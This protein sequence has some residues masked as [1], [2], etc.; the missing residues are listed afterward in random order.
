MANTAKALKNSA[1]SVLGQLLNLI[2]RFASRRIFI[3]FLD[4]EYLG[5]HSLFSNVLGLLSLTELG[6]GNVISFHLFKE[7][8]QNKKEE[9]GKL[10]FIY[11]WVYR[12]IALVVAILG[13]VAWFFL[14]KIVKNTTLSIEYVNTIYFLQL[15]SMVL[16]YL[17]AYKRNMFIADQKEYKCIKYDLIISIV[18]QIIA[19]IMLAF[20][21]SY[22]IYLILQ[23]S[24]TL[25]STLLISYETDISYPYLN[26]KYSVTM[27]DINKYNFIPDTKNFILHKVCYTVYS[28]TDNILISMYCGVRNVA[29]YGNYYTIQ[30]GILNILFYRLLNPIQATIGNIIY[31]QRPKE[32]LW[33][34]F[35]I[36]DFA[37]WYLACYTALGF[38]IF[39]QPVIELWMGKEYLLP[40]S[41][42]I[43]YVITIYFIASWEI[44][45]KYRSVFG[46]FQQDRNCMVLSA[47]LNII[48]SVILA[49]HLEI[50]GIQ[51]GTFFA[52]LPIAYGRIRFVVKNYFN[53]SIIK[54]Y[55]KHI[56]LF[57]IFVLDASIAWRITY[58]LPNTF[59]NFTIRVCVWFLI[60][61]TI[62][63]LFF[64]KTEDFKGVKSYANK[65]KEIIISKLKKIC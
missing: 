42:V 12:I 20:T 47:V 8:A 22:I 15:I 9:I 35:K 24:I 57:T 10:M 1:F 65:V 37:C 11:K 46:N 62:N 48:I 14:P 18:M 33:K 17:L 21:K 4:I 40:Y 19:L 64:F 7:I 51:I 34:Q 29:L 52:F 5:Y 45:Y 13:V 49:T 23:L 63:T 3:I 61:L 50:T 26:N 28:S 44:V 36:L 6:I 16:G 30:A 59:S 27:S 54:Y 32:N 43:A 58:Y 31:S 53:Q 60:P 55:L 56:L 38:L 2:L 39:F 41:F 25:I